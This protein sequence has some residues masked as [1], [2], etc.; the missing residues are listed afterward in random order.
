MLANESTK[1]AN[2][3]NIWTDKLMEQQH[4]CISQPKSIPS[5][6]QISVK[7]RL[8]QQKFYTISGW[9]RNIY[10]I[11]IDEIWNYAIN[12]ITLIRFWNQHW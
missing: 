1:M 7:A 12:L 5:Y 4:V 3:N 8:Q 11:Y 6:V 10:I 2:L 9:L